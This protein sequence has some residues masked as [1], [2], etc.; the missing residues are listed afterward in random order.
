MTNLAHHTGS[1][2]SNDEWAAALELAERWRDVRSDDS[3]GHAG[4]NLGTLAR[5]FLHLKICYDEA[6]RSE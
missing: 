6:V 3:H 5:A 2:I 1:S 4:K